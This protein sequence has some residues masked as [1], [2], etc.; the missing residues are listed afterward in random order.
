MGSNE[1]LL[2]L[3]DSRLVGTEDVNKRKAWIVESLPSPSHMPVNEHEREVMK[4]RKRLWIDQEEGIL[5]KRIDTLMADQPFASSGTNLKLEFENVGSG[6][7]QP[8]SIVL[9]L[10]APMGKKVGLA[11]RTVYHN[12]KFQKFDVQSTITVGP[13]D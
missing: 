7:W 8:I 4:F 5:L 13:P 10:H 11:N 6:V 3:F 1:E 12:S 2:T 9:D